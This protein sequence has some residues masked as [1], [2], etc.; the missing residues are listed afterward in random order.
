MR[1]KASLD[2]SCVVEIGLRFYKPE[3]VPEADHFGR[4][5]V[6]AQAAVIA[7]QGAVDVTVF[8][9]QVITEDGAAIAQVG[10]IIGEII[11]RPA[12]LGFPERHH[13]HHALSPD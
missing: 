9:A 6:F 2:L 3:V 10:G 12:Q 11:L 4:V 1:R 13:L 8:L 7:G 5:G